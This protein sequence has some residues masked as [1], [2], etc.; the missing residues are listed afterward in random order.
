[1]FGLDKYF[2]IKHKYR[3]SE[4]KLLLLSLIGG[5]LGAILGMNI[6]RHKTKKSKFVILV[7]FI[8]IVEAIIYIYFFK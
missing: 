8:F 4:K 6:F 3:I 5:S 1:M 2:A 7:P